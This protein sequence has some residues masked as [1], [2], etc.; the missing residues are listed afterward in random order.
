MLKY[1]LKCRQRG[2]FLRN[3]RKDDK[4]KYT[5]ASDFHENAHA[6]IYLFEKYQNTQIVLLGDF[7]DSRGNNGN[8]K[9]TAEFLTK[10]QQHKIHTKYEPIIIRGNHDDFIIGASNG[11]YEDIQF[12]LLNGGEKTLQELG[13]Q[14]S[15]ADYDQITKFLNEKYPDMIELLKY[16]Q[17]SYQT[18]H[19]IFVHA[20]LDLDLKDPYWDTTDLDKM[21]I[22]SDYYFEPDSKNPKLNTT[23]KTIITGHTPVQSIRKN[24]NAKIYKLHNENDLPSTNRFIIDGGSNSG[25]KSGRVIIL[26]V[27]ELGNIITQDYVSN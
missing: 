2:I 6:L 25:A 22:R 3:L 16:S 1:N 4:M 10:L 15:T 27:D 11:N 9:Q 13:F 21:W 12:W 23:N 20:G 19:L 14:E 8:A 26:Q 17:I 24:E 7:F 5:I 18:E